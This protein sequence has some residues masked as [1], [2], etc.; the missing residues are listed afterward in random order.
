M[1]FGNQDNQGLLKTKTSNQSWKRKETKKRLHESS[2]PTVFLSQLP[3]K[4]K[5][6]S[7]GLDTENTSTSRSSGEE[8]EV[9]PH[10][11][12]TKKG[13]PKKGGCHRFWCRKNAWKVV[14]VMYY[15]LKSLLFIC[16]FSIFNIA[17]FHTGCWQCP[18]VTH[19]PLEDSKAL[20]VPITYVCT[21]NVPCVHLGHSPG[22]IH[23]HSMHGSLF[24]LISCFQSRCCIYIHD[25]WL[26]YSIAKNTSV[27]R[28]YWRDRK[29]RRRREIEKRQNNRPR[30]H[31]TPHSV[32]S[33]VFF[34]ERNVRSCQCETA[35]AER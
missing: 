34:A 20:G 21:I 28:L 10:S 18:I 33:V 24:R 9:R 31:G 11:P 7:Q 26:M 27:P 8:A 32:A 2:K 25:S 35:K 13:D 19:C 30:N 14:T 6:Q 29:P 22:T 16:L 17:L 5:T 4:T 3:R 12:L 15:V 23:A 1:S